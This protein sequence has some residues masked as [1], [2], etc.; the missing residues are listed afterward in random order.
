ME[1]NYNIW[2]TLIKNYYLLQ[3]SPLKLCFEHM[4]PNLAR[5]SIIM[6]FIVKI[7]HKIYILKRNW[8]FDSVYRAVASIYSWGGGGG[9][10]LPIVGFQKI[11]V[12]YWPQ[13]GISCSFV[14]FGHDSRFFLYW[15][16]VLRWTWCLWCYWEC[17]S[18]QGKLEK[19]ALPRWESNLQPLEYYRAFFKN[20]SV[21]RP[22]TKR[23][24]TILSVEKW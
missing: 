21:G 13:L 1:R 4:R 15:C 11:G 22:S 20:L 23:D 8:L 14:E 12:Y 17:I 24:H 2:V 3:I 18:T 5:V 7:C 16:N 10:R 9:G 19:Y 6:Y